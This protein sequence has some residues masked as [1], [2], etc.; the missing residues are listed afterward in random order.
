MVGGHRFVNWEAVG[1]I[2][3][4]IGAAGVI[5]SLIYL[6]NQI[7]AQNAEFQIEAL[8]R[9][10]AGS[11]DCLSLFAEPQIAELFTR[12]NCGEEQLTEPEMLQ[13]IVCIQA[14]F[15]VWEEAYEQHLR[16]RLDADM[17]EAMTRQYAGNMGAP[18]FRRVWEIRKDGFRDSFRKYID[19]LPRVEYVS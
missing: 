4:V 8:H 5:A 16:G 1:T 17:W 13:L 12:F 14:L 2:A 18:A 9:I 10:S 19:E 6:A 15:R 7:R 11:R 3:E